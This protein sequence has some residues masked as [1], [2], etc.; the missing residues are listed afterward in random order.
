MLAEHKANSAKLIHVEELLV[1][2]YGPDWLPGLEAMQS[3][4][5]GKAAKKSRP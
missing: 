5:H 2:I 1:T 3:E 4:S